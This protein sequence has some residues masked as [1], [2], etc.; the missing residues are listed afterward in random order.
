MIVEVAAQLS[1][2][3]D[4]RDVDILF[5]PGDFQQ[6]PQGSGVYCTYGCVL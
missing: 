4:V 1:S 3:M 5:E 2:A 6:Y